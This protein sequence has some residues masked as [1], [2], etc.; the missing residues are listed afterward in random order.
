MFPVSA[1]L[2]MMMEQLQLDLNMVKKEPQY[3]EDY[4]QSAGNILDNIIPE[5]EFDQFGQGAP[6]VVRSWI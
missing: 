3:F 5:S 2:E 4:G 1:K 6:S